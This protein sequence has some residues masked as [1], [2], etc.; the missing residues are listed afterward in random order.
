MKKIRLL[1]ST[2]LIFVLGI[3]LCACGSDADKL[4][5]AWAGTWEFKDGDV[6]MH[7]N[8]DEYIKQGVK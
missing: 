7:D 4:L 1:I 6:I 3:S 5:G 8:G 2:V